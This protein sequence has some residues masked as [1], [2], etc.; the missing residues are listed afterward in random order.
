ML[1]DHHY[2]RQMSKL[3]PLFC[4]EYLFALNGHQEKYNVGISWSFEQV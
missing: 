4:M 1:S 3:G 2:D